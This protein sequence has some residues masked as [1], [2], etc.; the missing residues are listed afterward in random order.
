MR[1]FIA[2]LFCVTLLTLVGA[3]AC[4]AGQVP[5]RAAGTT[6]AG[7]Q[8]GEPASPADGA[9][10][11]PTDG[12]ISPTEQRWL[13]GAWPVVTYARRTGVPLDVIVQPQPVAGA[14]P[15]AMAFVDGRCK[16]VLSMRGNAQA[17]ATLDGIEPAL[18]D[19]TLELMVAHELGHCH[20]YLD[21]AWYGLPAGFV[22]TTRP[23]AGL[24]GELLAMYTTMQ[25]TRREEAFGD[26]VGLAWTRQHH[27]E[28]Y[29]RLHG[30][31]MTER[32]TDLIAGSHH[33]TLA[34][35]RL[36]GDGGALAGPSIFTGAATLWAS[37]LS[38][39]P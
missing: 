35:L 10:S 27:P 20:R 34:W 23:P 17:Q 14:A 30:W 2:E 15:L 24:Q 25:A 37:G 39:P 38:A 8:S 7:G 31:L 3:S 1:P 9:R 28:L 36:A 16:L 12:R 19:A 18:L 6:Q 4:L 26:L 5:G 13:Q 22:A 29:N 11:N 33:D 32:G 21:G